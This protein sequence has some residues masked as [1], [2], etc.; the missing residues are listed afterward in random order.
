MCH[1]IWL[2]SRKYGTVWY[3]PASSKLWY[4][5]ALSF[6][7]FQEK[8]DWHVLLLFARVKP[9][10]FGFLCVWR[11]V[12]VLRQQKG[13]HPGKDVCASAR[14]AGPENTVGGGYA[15]NIAPAHPVVAAGGC[16]RVCLRAN[17]TAPQPVSAAAVS[18]LR[19]DGTA[20]RA[21]PPASSRLQ[22]VSL[23]IE[24]RATSGRY[25]YG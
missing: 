11:R 22:H 2:L 10:L 14:E 12:H 25:G 1:P 17:K 24:S 7:N 6:V 8:I 5:T 15:A 21:L 20:L 18:D 19:G 4:L 23:A 16:S 9:A 13:H 3:H